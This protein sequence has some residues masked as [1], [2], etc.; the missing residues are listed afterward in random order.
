MRLSQ[1]MQAS[2]PRQTLLS[3]PAWPPCP[4]NRAPGSLP[5]PAPFSHPASPAC[6][7]LSLLPL[8]T[9]G[10]LN[11]PG[12]R[13]VVS[14]FLP[15]LLGEPHPSF[16]CQRSCHPS[17]GQ[18]SIPDPLLAQ[19]HGLHLQLDCYDRV[20]VCLPQPVVSAL[21]EGA[22]VHCRPPGPSLSHSER[23][24]NEWMNEWSLTFQPSAFSQLTLPP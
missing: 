12:V 3:S 22:C 23:L 17:L 24:L 4:Q 21:R 19:L 9:S 20:P 8:P 11:L 14:S 2:V 10:P 13:C 16:E 15:L 18:A 1:A 5:G 7:L 6:S